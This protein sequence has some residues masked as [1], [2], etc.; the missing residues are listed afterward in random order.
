MANHAHSSNF[1]KKPNPK[2]HQDISYSYSEYPLKHDLSC[3]STQEL[4]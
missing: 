1:N 3:A 2:N 4:K